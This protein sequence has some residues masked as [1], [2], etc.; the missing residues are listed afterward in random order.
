EAAERF[1]TIP[2]SA[3]VPGA[4]AAR[5]R[6]TIVSV[7]PSDAEERFEAL[8]R[9]P[10]STAGFAAIPLLDGQICIGVLGI[11][12][13]DPLE[14]RDLRFVEAVAAQVAQTIVRVRLSERGRRRRS[15]LEFLATL[16]DTALR[17]VDHV[18]LMQQVCA[19]AVPTLGDFCSLHYLPED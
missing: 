18:D 11:G 7:A 1:K 12:V 16:T 6:R 15:E 19:G 17:S 13:D 5:E 8:R 3:H 2:L 4:V 9:I 14:Q 10:R